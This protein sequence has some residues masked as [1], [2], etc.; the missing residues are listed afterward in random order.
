MMTEEKG[1]HGSPYSCLFPISFLHVTKGCCFMMCLSCKL[2]PLFRLFSFLTGLSLG[3]ESPYTPL[4]EIDQCFHR[5]PFSRRKRGGAFPLLEGNT[6]MAT[7]NCIPLPKETSSYPGSLF[8]TSEKRWEEGGI[9]T[10][11]ISSCD[12]PTLRQL[13][14]KGKIAPKAAFF[15]V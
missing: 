1:P 5:V 12:F 9:V 15:W 4:S 14:K 2:M 8:T 11:R 3:E 10:I 6:M 7:S 13:L